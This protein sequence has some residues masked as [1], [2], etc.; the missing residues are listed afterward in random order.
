MSKGSDIENISVAAARWVAR[1]DA[2]LS[3]GE[4]L[5][6]DQWLAAD[7]RHRAAFEHYAG[8]WSA[9]DTAGRPGRQGAIMREIGARARRRRGK[10]ACMTAATVCA[11]VFLALAALWQWPRA[12][13][14]WPEDSPPSRAVVLHPERRVLDDGSVVEI[15]PGAVIDVRY[16]DAARRIVLLRG[17]AHF[18]VEKGRPRPFVVAAGGMEVRAVGTAF[19]VEHGAAEV[20][21]WVTEGCVAVTKTPATPIV[22][23]SGG[24]ISP[25]A[26]IALSSTASI[27][28]ASSGTASVVMINKC[29]RIVVETVSEAAA[30]VVIPVSAAEINERLAWRIPRLEFSATPLAEAVAL[31]NRSSRLPDGSASARLVLDKSLAGLESEPVSGFF[32]ANNIEAFVQALDM[33][34]GIKGERRGDEIILRGAAR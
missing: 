12:K 14:L 22:P 27:T 31:I 17:E 9:F 10:R 13:G 18:Q 5:E 1:R 32:Y 30:P 29:E 11:V 19:A 8:T 3:P 33:S 34:M 24:E 21:V 2:G 16:D 4:A 25:D 28:V 26:T 20:E 23:V 15:K 6:F 7:A